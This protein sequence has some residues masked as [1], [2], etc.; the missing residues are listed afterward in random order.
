MP[1]RR[2]LPTEVPFLFVGFAADGQIE[3]AAMI[4]VD[5]DQGRRAAA[6]RAEIQGIKRYQVYRIYEDRGQGLRF[7]RE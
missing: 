7:E 1:G 3:T 6:A 4:R 5:Q 2:R